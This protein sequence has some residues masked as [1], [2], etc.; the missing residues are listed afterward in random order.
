[1]NKTT[2]VIPNYNGIK[3]L[4]PC[5]E[6]LYAQEADTP[7]FEVLVVDNASGDGSAEQA[8]QLFPDIRMIRLDVNTGFCHAV[9]VGIQASD[10]PYIILLNNDTK[11]SS[12]FVKALYEAIRRD[13]RIFSVSARMLMWDRPELIDDAGD[14][15]HVL[16]WAYARGKGKPAARYGKRAE[17]FSACGGAAIYRRS[18]LEEIGLFDELHFAYLEDLD[19]GYRA[20]IHGYRNLYEP[21]ARV[22][23]YGSASTGSRYNPRKTELSSANNVYVIYKNMPLIQIIWNMPFLLCGF[24]VKWLFFCRKHMGKIYLKG[25]VKGL[26]RCLGREGRS[27]KVTF[28]LSNLRHYLAIQWQLYVNLIL[29]LTGKG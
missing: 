20:R 3:F 17:I 27:H 19:I 6:S 14:R 10:S 4:K 25:L 21:K 2:I 1:M 8:E 23:H 13:S 29:F 24:F 12:G 9:N 26:K 18:I 15:Y 28:S 7:P 22:L 5:L 11:V 16:G